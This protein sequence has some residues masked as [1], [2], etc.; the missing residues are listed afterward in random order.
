ME[1]SGVTAAT[2]SAAV[3]TPYATDDDAPIPNEAPIP[4]TVTQTASAADDIFNG[5]ESIWNSVR[6]ILID[7]GVINNQPNTTAVNQANAAALAAV[8][9]ESQKRTMLIVG[10]VA[11]VALV[12]YLKK[13]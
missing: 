13:R 4:N 1:Q 2:L 12:I 8:Q 3:A 5:I 7:T 6:P 11:V 9:V 10:A